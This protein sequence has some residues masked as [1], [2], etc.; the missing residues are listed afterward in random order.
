MVKYN[1][2]LT[3]YTIRHFNENAISEIEKGREVL[4]KQRSRE[5]VQIIT[6]S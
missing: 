3:L 1:K 6:K 5:T 4:L 2:G